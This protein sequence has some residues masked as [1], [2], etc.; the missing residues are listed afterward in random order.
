MHLSIA[1][2]ATVLGKSERQVR[3]LIRQGKLKAS[4]EGARWRIESENLP[5]SQAER[6]QLGDKL[7]TAREQVAAAF[8]PLAKATEGTDAAKTTERYSV[9]KLAAFEVGREL[10]RELTATLGESHPATAVLFDALVHLTQGCHAYR[11]EDKA[12][13]FGEARRLAAT[14][15]AHL[16]V[17]QDGRGEALAA[18]LEQELIPKIGGLVAAQEKGRRRSSRFD[19]FGS[20]HGKDR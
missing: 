2:A 6:Q 13:S 17:D 16:F 5:L 20:P 11:P 12:R 19:R 9:R 10:Y 14:A 7:A 8:E 3:Y 18:R 4:K 1:E 15:T